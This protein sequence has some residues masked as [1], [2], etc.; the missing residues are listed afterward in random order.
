M[1]WFLVDKYDNIVS[2]TDLHSDYGKNSA[3]MY[4]VGR[5]RVKEEEF[6]KLWEVMSEKEYDLNMEAFHRKPSSEQ[7]EWW[8][9][10]WTNPDIDV[11]ENGK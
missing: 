9:D 10:E 5:K 6:D 2:R 1:K 3:K 7:Y 4:F 8:K 11:I